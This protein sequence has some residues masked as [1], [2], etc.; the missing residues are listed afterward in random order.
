MSRTLIDI[1]SLNSIS[2]NSILMEHV[3]G[4]VLKTVTTLWVLWPLVNPE[5]L[6]QTAIITAVFW[7]KKNATWT[8][9][10]DDPLSPVD[11]PVRATSPAVQGRGAAVLK[12][13]LLDI[14]VQD[15]RDPSWWAGHDPRPHRQSLG[16]IQAPPLAS[17]RILGNA[18]CRPH[19][20]NHWPYLIYKSW[21]GWGV[22]NQVIFSVVFPI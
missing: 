14:P 20:E 3:H 18:G 9:G 11:Q 21:N 8:D 5:D 15:L 19:F 10:C 22:N 2:I 12:L 13:S 6:K 7:G 4:I 1:I 17:L 16:F